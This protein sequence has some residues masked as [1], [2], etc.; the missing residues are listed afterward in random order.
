MTV[1][2]KVNPNRLTYGEL[3]R[4]ARHRAWPF[5]QAVYRKWFNVPFPAT[6][7]F[8][9]PES[10][11]L[12]E[13][14]KLPGRAREVLGEIISQAENL[15]FRPLFCWQRSTLGEIKD[16]S[17]VLLSA[18]GTTLGAAIWVTAG[19]RNASA[20]FVAGSRC[21]ERRLITSNSTYTID[22]PPELEKLHFPG[23]S[24]DEIVALHAL[25]LDRRGIER[26]QRATETDAA[27]RI[28]EN[29]QRTLAF[30]LARGVYEPMTQEEIDWLSGTMTR[31]GAA[32]ENNP[33]QA[34]QY[35]DE[36][37]PAI[38]HNEKPQ[39][40]PPAPPNRPPPKDTWWGAT[41]GGFVAGM[42]GGM[43]L[44]Q[45]QIPYSV[46]K[47]VEQWETDF[48]MVLSLPFL[49]GLLGGAV[50]FAAW[51]RRRGISERNKAKKTQDAAGS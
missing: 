38:K 45:N 49:M 34:P 42:L 3:W 22:G 4:L 29:Q 17:A 50:S 1:W 40:A 44:L 23:K 11:E 41:G 30:N 37:R 20:S 10:L 24:I 8:A 14:Q 36:I 16:Y 2:Y 9:F 35:L 31:V 43:I 12:V 39:P 51:L 18:D 46:Y 6:S 47:A 15:G 13:F 48:G 26:I 28:L 7:G 25:R 5:A 19:G 33:Y 21:E 32:A 27:E